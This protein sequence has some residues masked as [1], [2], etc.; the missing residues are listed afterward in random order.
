MKRNSKGF[1][2][3]EIM[4]AVTI[5][6]TLLAIVTASIS[7]IRSKARN[8]QVMADKQNLIL[9]L[10]KAREASPTYSYP[11]VAGWQCIKAT[12]SCWKN[13]Y[14]GNSTITAALTP[15]LPAQTIPIPPWKDTN[16]HRTGAYTYNP[17]VVNFV[18]VT[19][20]VLVWSQDTPIASSTC[21]GATFL[22]I[23]A[24]YCAEILPR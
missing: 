18:G 6:L 12:G 5:S 19:G 1:S 7:A 14:T 11:G 10:V 8:A 23:N 21:N 17:Y 16:Q 4:V 20:P 13:A 2:L 9:A 3:V 22:S 24:Y 15:Y